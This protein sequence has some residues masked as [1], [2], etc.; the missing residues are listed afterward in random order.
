MTCTVRPNINGMKSNGREERERERERERDRERERARE[1]GEHQLGATIKLLIAQFNAVVS[2]IQYRSL[3]FIVW[4]R[5]LVWPV[6]ITNPSVISHHI[7][8]TYTYT[9]S[10]F[11]H[12]K[13]VR[14]NKKKR[15]T[16]QIKHVAVAK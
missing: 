13:P 14:S 15:R 12:K 1:R 11:N 7:Y 16:K 9:Y 10:F 5:Q 4:L 6:A 2:T 3:R 8:N